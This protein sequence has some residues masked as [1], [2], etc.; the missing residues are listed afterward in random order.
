MKL[1]TA[2]AVALPLTL[3]FAAAEEDRE[4]LLAMGRY[5]ELVEAEDAPRDGIWAFAR[6]FLVP[7]K[8][9]Y[10]AALKAHEKGDLLGTFI[11]MRCHT[12]GAG[13]RVD[14]DVRRACNVTLR[15]ALEKRED[16]SAR[17]S[18][19]LSYLSQADATGTIHADQFEPE[20]DAYKVAG[21]YG[22]EHRQTSAE[23]GFA[24]AMVEEGLA[25]QS[26][27]PA[28][29]TKWYR[30]A[31]DLGHAGGMKDL[32]FMLATGRSP[33]GKDEKEA[34]RWTRE[35][36]KRGNIYAMINVGAFFDRLKI[37]GTSEKE[38]R[39]SIERAEKTGH[40]LGA[41]EKGLALLNGTYGYEVD[42]A[43]GL[44][45]LQKGAR[46]GH[47][48]AL[49]QLAY[50]YSSGVGVEIDYKMAAELGKASWLQGREY[51]LQT[52][53]K[54]YQR[55][56]DLAKDEAAKDYWELMAQGGGLAF[57]L[58]KSEPEGAVAEELEKI[59]PFGIK[60]R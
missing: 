60:L 36:A 18:Y 13:V 20:E 26:E 42:K 59:D 53:A 49:G 58:G 34:M 28:A 15:E 12:V 56:E 44:A 45:L 54:C 4:K 14:H 17:D 9:T 11:V 32:G 33:D 16:P 47:S 23:S 31:A 19:L 2:F 43:A 52:I 37:E 3:C 7:D 10:T 41:L 6:F 30:N 35:A 40:Y 39:A 57:A 22:H 50:F 38:A 8:T 51:A 27:D 24:Q 48:Y 5:Q 46:S 29:A 55:D 25:V 1:L 21:K